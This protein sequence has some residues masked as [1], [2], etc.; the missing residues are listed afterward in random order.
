MLLTREQK[1]ICDAMRAIAQACL[2]RS[3]ARTGWATRDRADFSAP[4]SIALGA[5]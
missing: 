2:W 1:V 5:G 3:A 4:E